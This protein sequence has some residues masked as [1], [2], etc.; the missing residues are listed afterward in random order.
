MVRR[1]GNRA[2]STAFESWAALLDTT[3]AAE[4]QAAAELT[5]AELRAA[6]NSAEGRV[7]ALTANFDGWQVGRRRYSWGDKGAEEQGGRENE[8]VCERES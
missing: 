6:L 2:L 1:F 7:A 4:Q 8:C 3:R 5:H